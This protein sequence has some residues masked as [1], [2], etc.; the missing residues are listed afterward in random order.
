MQQAQVAQNWFAMAALLAWPLVAAWLYRS[1]SVAE[2]TLWTIL[3]GYLSWPV[4]ASVK[5]GSGIPPLDKVSIPAL[6]ALAGCFFGSHRQLRFWNGFGLAEILL[7]MLLVGP[8]V[9]SELNSDPVVS[10]GVSLPGV[11]A[12][13]GSA[14]I[15]AQFLFVLPF[16]LGRRVLSSLADIEKILKS[17]VVAGLLSTH[18]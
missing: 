1:R 6:S 4:G 8:F 9:T 16:F 17:L 18:C 2:A 11:G 15:V 12:Y 5:L 7:L 3:A 14:A 10:G 13:D